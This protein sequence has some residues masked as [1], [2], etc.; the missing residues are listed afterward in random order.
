ME[1]GKTE[2]ETDNEK[3]EQNGLEQR[4]SETT[5]TR[6]PREQRDRRKEQITVMRNAQTGTGAQ[7]IMERVPT[8]ARAVT[9]RQR[10]RAHRQGRHR[11][12]AGR[13]D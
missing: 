5:A 12:T 8:A 9:E 7:T 10:E 11:G 1:T 2:N 6:A 3:N 4:Q 13:N